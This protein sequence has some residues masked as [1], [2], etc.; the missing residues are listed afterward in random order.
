M[1]EL[2]GAVA[3]SRVSDGRSDPRQPPCACWTTGSS[4]SGTWA[5]PLA[6]VCPAWSSSGQAALHHSSPK[7]PPRAVSLA[8]LEGSRFQSVPALRASVSPSVQRGGGT[9]CA[10][11]PAPA[12]CSG[13]SPKPCSSC[14][15]AQDWRGAHGSGPWEGAE[16]RR[17]NGKAGHPPPE[18]ASWL[19]CGGGSRAQTQTDRFKHTQTDS[20]THR[21]PHAQQAL[22]FPSGTHL[23]THDS[24]AS[25]RKPSSDCLHPAWDRGSTTPST[26]LFIEG[27]TSQLTSQVPPASSQV[28]PPSLERGAMKS[29]E[30]AFLPRDWREGRDPQ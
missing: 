19:L 27:V 24:P 4:S 11:P 29:Q 1:P 26:P 20:D 25:Q 15:Q 17:G 5:H 28:T 9:R 8:G 14:F 7:P 10:P 2:A 16:R 13:V 18:E 21:N 3:F 30:G 22:P 23:P 6:Q 12:R